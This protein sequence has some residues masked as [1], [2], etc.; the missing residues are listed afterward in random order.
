MYDFYKT[1]GVPGGSKHFSEDVEA[2]ECLSCLYI[3]L[4]EFYKTPWVPRVPE[5]FSEVAEAPECLSSM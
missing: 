4:Y 2:T 1:S 3:F 5:H